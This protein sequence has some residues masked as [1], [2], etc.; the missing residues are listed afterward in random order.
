MGC[1]GCLCNF[2]ANSCE[3]SVDYITAGE[4]DEP[5]YNCD[6]CRHYDGDWSKRSR[7]TKECLNYK[8]A[9]KH[10]E[11]RRKIEN[12]RAEKRRNNFVVLTGGKR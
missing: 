1:Y 7:W 6:D 12:I 11:N 4:C 8:E 2:C 10:V 9:Q 3:L 5:C